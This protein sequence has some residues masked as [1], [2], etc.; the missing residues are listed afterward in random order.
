MKMKD[1]FSKEQRKALKEIRQINNKSK[2]YPLDK[3]SVF[4][5][6]SEEDAIN[7]IEEQLGK[8]KAIDEDPTHKCT[9]K[10]QKQLC[11][12]RK[13]KKFTDKEYFEIYSSDPIP[14]QLYGAVKAHTPEKNYPMRTVL[15]TTGT[16]PCGIY[17]YLVKIIQPTLNKSP[18]KI[19][20][21]VEFANEAKTWKI[22]LTEIQVSY[23]VTNLFPSVFF[24]KA[25]DAI[26]EY[27]K[28]DLNNVRTRTKLA[29]V[30]IHQVIDLC[31]SE[32]YFLYNNL[33]W[34]LYNS[35]PIGLPIMVVLSECYLQRLEE[36]SIA[37]YFPLNISPKTFKRYVDDNHARFENKQKISSVH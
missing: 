12:L 26:V 5:V 4:V 15:S 10:I 37:L 17:K 35:G 34:K 31:L 1:N 6:L 7:K 9:S 32:H 13:E 22:S 19:K 33:I 11:K 30:D 21:S 3:G 2:V 27:L 23:D 28:N 36:K 16:S 24:D 20:N 25:I 14:P 29:L 8:A 18:H